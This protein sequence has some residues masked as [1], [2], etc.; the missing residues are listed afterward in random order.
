MTKEKDKAL[1]VQDEL[2]NKIQENSG[3]GEMPDFAFIPVINIDNS[4]EEKKVDG[5]DVD[6]RCKARFVMQTGMEEGQ[7]EII[8]DKFQG[9]VAKVKYF[10]T[11][12]YEPKPTIPFF[13]SEEFESS[14]F[15]NGATFNI[16]HKIEGGEDEIEELSY[17]EFKEKFAGL[18]KLNAILYILRDEQLVKVRLKGSALSELWNYLKKF[19][20]KDDSVSFHETVFTCIRKK[21]PQP[22]NTLALSAGDDKKVDLAEVAKTQDQLIPKSNLV[23]ALGGRVI[24][25]DESD[26]DIKVESIPFK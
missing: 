11:K 21:E 7:E 5:E 10:V 1:S 9:V 4:S 24:N 23:K 20:A 16:K 26:D 19:N 12:R 22:Y 15:N 3:E 6:V 17:Q 2:R 18:Y 8:G 25:S 13:F 14:I